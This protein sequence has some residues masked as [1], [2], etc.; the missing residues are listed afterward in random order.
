MSTK[1]ETIILGIIIINTVI[2]MIYMLTMWFV[3]RQP[4]V[5]LR[6]ITMLLCPVVGICCY[7]F[8]FLFEILFPK[9]NV[10]YDNLSMDKTKKEFLETVD[11]EN[12]MEVLPLEEV[13][14]VSVATP[15]TC[16]A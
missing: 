1:S 16:H 14:T 6:G 13:L 10:D 8:C 5:F 12:E 2:A 4:H 11:K 15:K 7:F 9:G 3:K